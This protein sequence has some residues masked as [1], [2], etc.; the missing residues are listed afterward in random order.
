MRECALPVARITQLYRALRPCGGGS[1][2]VGSR[3]R[4]RGFLLNER[5]KRLDMLAF[6]GLGAD[7]NPRHPASVENGG[8][9]IRAAGAV[10]AIHPGARVCV[11]RLTLEIFRL[12]P[13]AD[14]LQRHRG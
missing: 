9:E 8:S 11:E 12:V 2:C 4:A 5:P 7:R 13:Y 14:G 1:A 6:G 10:H 3:F